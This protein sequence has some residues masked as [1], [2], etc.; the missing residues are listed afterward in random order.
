MLL[1]GG[2][3]RLSGGKHLHY[4]DSPIMPNLLVTLMDKLDMP[5]E[6]V[7]GSTG[8]LQVDPELETLSGV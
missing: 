4:T 7:G 6:Q 1:G 2:A 8:R 5:L 3:G